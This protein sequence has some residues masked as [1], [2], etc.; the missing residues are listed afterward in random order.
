MLRPGGKQ[1]QRKKDFKGVP[2]YDEQRRKREEQ[3]VEI[4]KNQR[5]ESLQ[6]KRR[7]GQQVGSSASTPNFAPNVSE[8]VPLAECL[9]RPPPG[10]SLTHCLPPLQLKNLPQMVQGVHSEDYNTQL[11]ATI[12]FRKLLS[13]GENGPPLQQK[14]E[15]CSLWFIEL[16][17]TNV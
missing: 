13:I 8:Q 6:K 4:R 9:P 11:E 1:E 5:E 17:I 15:I 2:G 12:Q 10:G 7:G 3:M 16:V 14:R